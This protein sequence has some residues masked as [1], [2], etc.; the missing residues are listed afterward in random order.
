[1]AETVE[2]R[3]WWRRVEEVFAG[4]LDLPEAD[5]AAYLEKACAGDA[6]LQAEVQSLL[7]Y[8]T[9]SQEGLDRVVAEAAATYA[10]ERASDN[11]V[12]SDLGL[13]VGRFQIVRELARGGMGVVY[14]G[15]RTDSDYAQVVAIKLIRSGLRSDRFVRRFRAE[16]QFLASLHHPNIA[17]I[18]DGGSTP[19]GRPYIV[20]E[21]IEGDPITS[22][23][24][25]R[26]LDLSARVQLMETVSKAVGYAHRH[27]VLHRDLKPE[28]ILVTREEVVKLVDFGIAKLLEPDSEHARQTTSSFRFLT[29]A[30]ASPEQIAGKP[31]SPPSDVYSLGI[32][33]YEVLTGRHPW[34][35][36][37]ST[38]YK[39][40]M[41]ANRKTPPPPSRSPGG[42]PELKRRI[43]SDLDKVV[44]KAMARDPS[45]RYATAQELAADLERWRL[46]MPVSVGEHGRL[47]RFWR[48][49]RKNPVASGAIAVAVLLA[50]ALAGV[51]WRQA[52]V[53]RRWRASTYPELARARD[54]MAKQLAA[55]GDVRAAA[56]SFADCLRYL[57]QAAEAGAADSA[58]DPLKAQCSTGAAWAALRQ[59]QAEKAAAL[60]ASAV[61]TAR[62]IG[63]PALLAA[64]LF[65]D[66]DARSR[67]GDVSGADERYREA[68]NVVAPGMDLSLASPTP[69]TAEQWLEFC[70]EVPPTETPT[71]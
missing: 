38:P 24:R 18:L 65:A 16:K 47:S 66:G 31:V 34:E 56:D 8:E 19:D 59:D 22:Y 11:E 58:L 26:K 41:E 52:A 46:Q 69:Q 48:T 39:L 14:L 10:S 1:M 67:R 53:E 40:F 6:T 68:C 5:R 70:R 61:E 30:Y 21:Y 57:R 54:F 2:D 29:P 62:S 33:L 13:R 23:C 63:Q 60:A 71:R 4:A 7:R 49:V 36:F 64:A 43:D 37:R 50:A 20:L 44:L 51:I 45:E 9:V 3:D 28:N 35:E 25:Q 17:M 42:D 12:S 55:G 15:V 32:I 27:R